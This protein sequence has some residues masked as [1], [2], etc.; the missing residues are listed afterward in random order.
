MNTK[1]KL[2][3]IVLDCALNCTESTVS[4][5]EDFNLVEDLNYD[6]IDFINLIIKIED[7]FKFEFTNTELLTDN[8]NKFSVL[9][10]VVMSNLTKI[11][12]KERL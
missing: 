11:N 2:F 9:S 6:S 10:Q 3:N 8:I 4:S 12:E 5:E 1:E 7:A